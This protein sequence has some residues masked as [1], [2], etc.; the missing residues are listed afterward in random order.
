M[1][2]SSRKFKARVHVDVKAFEKLIAFVSK[3]C[4]LAHAF[5]VGKKFRYDEAHT[6]EYETRGVRKIE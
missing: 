6:N 5:R 4:L 1:G 2:V 3:T